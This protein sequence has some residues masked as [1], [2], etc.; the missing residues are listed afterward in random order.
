MVNIQKAIEVAK[1]LIKNYEGLA[2]ST[3]P[4]TLTYVRKD[5]SPNDKIYAYWD[6]FAKIYTIGWGSIYLNGRPVKATDVITRAQ[7]ETI[8]EQEVIEK[9]KSIRGKVDLNK[10]NENQYAVLISIAYNAGAAGLARTRIL[11]A[12]NTGKPVA[13]VAAIIADSLTTSRGAVVPGLVRR[14][15]EESDFFMQIPIQEFVSN[16]K[17]TLL[18]GIVLVGIGAYLFYLKKK[19]IFKK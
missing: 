1:P 14:R 12:I 13:E 8:F 7:A 6:T 18:I 9:E 2:S 11:P 15:R 10:V 19:G 16:N 5:G 17:N 3:P 4:P